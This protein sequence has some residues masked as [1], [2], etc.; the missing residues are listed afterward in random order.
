MKRTALYCASERVRNAYIMHKNTALAERR[1][2]ARVSVLSY[3]GK[4]L[5]NKEY[6]VFSVCNLH[7]M[8]EN[9]DVMTL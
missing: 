3:F 1:R 2:M 5:F 6:K 7:D 8:K 4:P 9:N